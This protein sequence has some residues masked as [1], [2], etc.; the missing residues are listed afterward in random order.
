MPIPYWIAKI[1]DCD[2][3]IAACPAGG[4]ALE[5]ELKV[6]KKSESLVMI[7][8]LTEKEERRLG[9]T[10]EK[11]IAEELGIRFIKFPIPDMSIPGFKIYVEFIDH[12]YELTMEKD[13]MLIHCRAGI[14]RSS[15]IAL[16]LMTKDGTPLSQSIQHV[17]RTR[18]F[19]VPQSISQRRLLHKYASNKGRK[20]KVWI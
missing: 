15:L 10:Q 20:G 14:G 7:S 12:L 16:G 5:E 8:L 1:N 3:G 11:L 18:G 6:F 9:L 4:R 13:K 19:H 2:I 17:S